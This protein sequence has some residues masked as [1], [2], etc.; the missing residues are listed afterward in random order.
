MHAERAGARAAWII[1]ALAGAF[2]V[3]LALGE[4]FWQTVDDAFMVMI[5][6]RS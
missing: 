2:A 1:G 6:M 5:A 4:P 3:P